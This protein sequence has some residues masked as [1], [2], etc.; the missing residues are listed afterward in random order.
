MSAPM[1]RL[2][3][4]GP[5]AIRTPANVITSLRLVLA[6]PALFLVVDV[7]STWLTVG[8]W[9]VL[10]VTDGLDGWIARRDGTTRAGA[11]LDPLADKFLAVGGFSALAI[12]GDIS[13][14]PVIVIAGREVLISIYR[15]IEGRKGISLPAR[16]LGKWKTFIQMAAI[17]FVL[18][19]LT[20]DLRWLWL[21][22]IWGAVV[23]TVVSGIDVIAAARR[24]IRGENS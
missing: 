21:S 23:L 11:F 19:P 9:F 24:P 2:R 18:L 20:A 4:F 17:G 22:A 7:G 13:W 6:I 8:L 3:R 1:E 15:S 12:R 10:S 16:Q 5:G 14:I